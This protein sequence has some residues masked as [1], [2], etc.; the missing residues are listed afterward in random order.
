MSKDLYQKYYEETN[1]GKSAENSC[2]GVRLYPLY[3]QYLKNPII[4]L[5]CGT[6]D[7][8]M[9]LR[10]G[11]FEAN[12]IDWIEYNPAMMVGDLT[13]V[14]MSKYKTALCID[15]FEHIDDE[16]VNGILEVVKDKVFIV[17]VHNG[18]G[19]WRPGD[20]D[21]HINIKPFEEWEK[22]IQGQLIKEVHGQPRLYVRKPC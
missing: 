11:G 8:V 13:D 1:Y 19:V 3:K 12:G 9:L 15:V 10:K 14:D 22:I 21:L 20:P 17:S 6:G 4:D 2:P 16:K 5:G 18:P 7:T